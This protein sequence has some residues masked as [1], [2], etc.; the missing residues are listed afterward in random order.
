MDLAV[1]L[2][3]SVSTMVCRSR[4]GFSVPA[5]KLGAWGRSPRFNKRLDEIFQPFLHLLTKYF[6]YVIN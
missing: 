4:T 6:S 3:L 2:C 5:T 1:V